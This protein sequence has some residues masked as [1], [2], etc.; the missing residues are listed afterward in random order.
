MLLSSN[1]HHF[2]TTD[3]DL[4]LDEWAEKFNTALDI[5][6]PYVPRKRLKRNRKTCPFMTKALLDLIRE[7]KS[8]FKKLKAAN[9]RDMVIMAQFK[10]LRSQSNNLYR[11]L[12]NRYFADRCRTYEREPRQFWKL[13]N[14]ITKRMPQR[15]TV[16]IPAERQ[17]GLSPS[18][19]M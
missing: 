2:A 5:A 18:P 8:A 3:T 9:F 6:A 16:T 14:T 7:R 10:R 1:L 12:Q 4:M 11:H 19:F 13:L 17:L 15:Q